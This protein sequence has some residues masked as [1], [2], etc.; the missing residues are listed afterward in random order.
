VST[1]PP[2]QSQYFW[3]L[4][5]VRNEPPLQSQYFW[6]LPLVSINEPPLQSQNFWFLPLVSK[7]PTI[8]SQYFRL[9][10]LLNLN[11]KLSNTQGK[12]NSYSQTEGM[13]AKLIARKEKDIKDCDHRNRLSSSFLFAIQPYTKNY[14]VSYTG[15]KVNG[16]FYGQGIYRYLNGSVYEGKWVNSKRH[17]LGIMKWS[18]GERYEGEWEIDKCHGHGCLYVNGA[19][20]KGQF[21][22][23]EIKQNYA[24]S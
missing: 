13:L 16:R 2:L 24:Q 19:V 15:G 14:E 11:D 6:L 9:K 10:N 20:Y 5:L 3:F 18:S 12:V 4:P 7:E 22:H 17:G 8:Q 21:E 23:G 1:E